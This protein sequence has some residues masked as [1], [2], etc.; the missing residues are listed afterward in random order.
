LA[1]KAFDDFVH[2]FIDCIS[3]MKSGFTSNE[4]VIYVASVKKDET[5]VAEV[6]SRDVRQRTKYCVQRKCHST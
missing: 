1:A 4:L 2:A 6:D 3:H 5:F